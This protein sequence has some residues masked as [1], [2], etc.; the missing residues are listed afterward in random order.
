[1]ERFW[2]IQPRGIHP[3]EIKIMNVHDELQCSIRIGNEDRVRAIRDSFLKEYASLI[4]LI[5]MDW[6]TG[7]NWGQTH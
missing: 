7:T 3:Y 5:K 4:P 2:E 6:K 1:M